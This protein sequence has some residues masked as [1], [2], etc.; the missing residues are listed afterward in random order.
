MDVIGARF[1]DLS[2][3][4]A[5]RDAILAVVAVPSADVAVRALGT[6]RYDQPIEAFV[7]AGRFPFAAAQDVV[8]LMRDHGGVIISRRFEG[9][10]T[11]RQP[12]ATTT[13]AALG[14]LAI[15]PRVERLRAAVRKRLRRPSAR[16]RVR[17]ARADRA[18]RRG[19]DG[20]PPRFYGRAS[21]GSS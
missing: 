17:A 5:A 16:L 15:R 13:G 8:R 6:T 11:G 9:P 2:A 4:M 1:A 3:A 21:T 12:E 18:G 14:S 10:A 19:R 7:L 20:G